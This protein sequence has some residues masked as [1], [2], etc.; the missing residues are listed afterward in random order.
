MGFISDS[1]KAK[2][3]SNFEL[4]RIIAMLLIIA[5]HV[6]MHGPYV[7]LASADYYEKFQA[8]YFNHPYFYKQLL[9]VGVIMPLG[10]VAND[11]FI[12]ISGY[13]L[14]SKEHIN[15]GKTA[16]KLISQLFFGMLALMVL[17]QIVFR[18]SYQPEME[19]TLMNSGF[20][21]EGFWFLGYYFVIILFGG[22][23]LNSFLQKLTEKQY[24]VFILALFMLVQSTWTGGML[25]SIAN[26]LRM[27]VMGV[28]L[29]ALGG[30]IRKF[31][32]FEKY[33]A[34]L[35]VVVIAVM[36]AVVVLSFYN[37]SINYIVK[38]GTAVPFIQYILTWENYNP[39]SFVIAVCLFELFRRIHIPTNR[40]INFFGESTLLV[41]VMHENNFIIDFYMKENWLTPL[42]EHPVS[43][44]LAKLLLWSVGLFLFGAVCY[45]VYK[46][47]MVLI[48]KFL[49]LCLKSDKAVQ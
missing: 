7:Q 19:L 21:N 30:Y 49:T 14:A 18:V 36:M 26:G 15:L 22:I 42:W 29:Y 35:F 11:I 40:V 10:F 4:L 39:V 45:L 33:R 32:P 37:A 1:K 16:G 8:D 23:W 47:I 48:K 31:N 38:S 9:S 25:D 12:L 5:F 24:L 2:R 17:S 41:Y 13:F 28:C 46:F 27:T 20:A 44:F 6:V 43:G 34:I 3:D